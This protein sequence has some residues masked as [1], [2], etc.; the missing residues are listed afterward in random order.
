M[1]RRN[2][3][4]RCSNSY[5]GSLTA[6]RRVVVSRRRRRRSSAENVSPSSSVD[7]IFSGS[8]QSGAD[9]G[10][11]NG[12]HGSAVLGPLRKTVS[13]LQSEGSSGFVRPLENVENI[14]PSA[15]RV[16]RS[17]A[18][19][20]RAR[21][22]QS[23]CGQLGNRL[24]SAPDS[25]LDGSNKENEV[26]V[27][28]TWK[29]DND[30]QSVNSQET[31][32]GAQAPSSQASYDPRDPVPDDDHFAL[33]INEADLVDI[34]TVSELIREPNQ[35]DI[36]SSSLHAG[37]DDSWVEGREKQGTASVSS[38]AAGEKLSAAS[39]EDTVPETP[40]SQ[41]PSRMAM[42]D[43]RTPENLVPAL[44]EGLSPSNGQAGTEGRVLVYDRRTNKRRSDDWRRTRSCPQPQ[45]SSKTTVPAGAGR[46][47]RS[48]GSSSQRSKDV[49]TA[50]KDNNMLLP[51]NY[52]QEIA[53]YFA[54]VDAFELQVEE[55]ED[56]DED[57]ELPKGLNPPAAT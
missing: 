20:S 27:N 34:P 51:E 56:E 14:L 54:E 52:R 50:K 19:R 2:K 29:A 49:T 13:G 47:G 15:T 33:V 30:T 31:H 28:S 46:R 8:K 4:G 22:L 45:K 48:S 9:G 1:P 57:K 7:V 23:T 12:A 37:R 32:A 11:R 6:D 42:G 41:I 25:R 40:R 17:S 53:A 21:A 35:A 16:T 55:E 38:P 26:L 43:M 3:S 5:Q 39:S 24:V 10:N 44:R 36:A 18:E